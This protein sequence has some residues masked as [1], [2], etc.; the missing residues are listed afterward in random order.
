MTFT[1]IVP[2]RAGSKGLPGKNLR[3]LAG[4]PLWH[5]A[6]EQA[7][8]AQAC[9]IVVS[10]DIPAIIEADH[11]ED[12]TIVARPAA[13][14]GDD[15]PMAPVLLHAIEAADVTGNVVLLQ[16]TS[17]LREVADIEAGLALYA[18][19][20][21]D[22][23]MSVTEADR[24]VLKY[25]QVADGRFEALVDPAHS[26]MNRQSL[27]P[28]FRP[29]GAVYVFGAD[30]FSRNGGFQSDRIGALQMPADRSGDIDTEEDFLRIEALLRL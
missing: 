19:L 9:R 15:T 27:P 17:P 6:V 23:V 12:V 25:G 2:V 10:T 5:R 13:L 14:G 28:V 11:P 16:C 18:T 24:S 26:F 20:A 3:P 30:W 1:A 8:A 4:V 7:R 21:F 22:L 29:N